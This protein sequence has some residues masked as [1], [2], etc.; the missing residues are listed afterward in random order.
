MTHLILI[1]YD[2]NIRYAYNHFLQR[3]KVKISSDGSIRVG[4]VIWKMMRH[5]STYLQRLCEPLHGPPGVTE[6]HRHVWG[7]S[8]FSHLSLRYL[9]SV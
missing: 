7:M 4:R 5:H 3:E 8:D 6:G 1:Y 9:K 2:L